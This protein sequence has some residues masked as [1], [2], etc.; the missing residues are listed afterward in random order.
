M[1]NSCISL[2]IAGLWPCPG[3]HL[4]LKCRL[5]Q[6]KWN[7]NKLQQNKKTWFFLHANVFQITHYLQ[8]IRLTKNISHN[9]ASRYLNILWGMITYRRVFILWQLVMNWDWSG[10]NT[11]IYTFFKDRGV[12]WHIFFSN[13]SINLLTNTSLL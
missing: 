5:V 10:I 8:R 9:A 12:H 3:N 6:I 1:I 7:N 11:S 13:L 4:F 2:S